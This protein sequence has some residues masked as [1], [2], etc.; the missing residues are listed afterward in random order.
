MFAAFPFAAGAH[1][2]S[3]AYLTL[4][5]DAGAPVRIQFDVA[6]RDLDFVLHLDDDGDG[7]ITW[8]EL[9]R[10]QAEIVRY[11]ASGIQFSAGAAAC[12]LKPTRQLVDEHADGAYAALFFEIDCAAASPVRVD[13]R[14][15]FP[16]DPSHRAIVVA[17]AGTQVA[18]A[19]LSPE[20]AR[21][22]FDL[23]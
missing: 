4:T 2:A 13:Y 19:L 8:G 22:E 7:R 21:A 11:V 10:H 17:R 3:D 5:H 23:R 9:K 1:S 14:L 20:H 15:F 18:T 16:V 12:A 6:L